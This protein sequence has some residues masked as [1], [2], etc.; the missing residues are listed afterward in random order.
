MTDR[1]MFHL[2][3]TIDNVDHARAF[4]GAILGCPEGRKLPGRA[5]FNFFGHHLVTHEAA[6]EYINGEDGPKLGTNKKVPLRHFGVI[7]NHDQFKEIA[8]KL[9]AGG[10]QLLV[11]VS[12]I[13]I[14]EPREQQVMAC[15][16]GCGNVLEFKGLPDVQK[17]FA[18]A[19]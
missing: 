4:Y 10:V 5:D 2:S 16:D 7:V 1:P 3:L 18:A 9:E 19:A 15:A 12:M 17:I 14:G 8:A 6:P 13:G 11:P